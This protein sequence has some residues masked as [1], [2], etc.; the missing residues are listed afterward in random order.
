MSVSHGGRLIRQYDL[1]REIDCV[2]QLDSHDVV[3]VLSNGCL[4]QVA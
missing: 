1:Q 2:T 3:P 4:R